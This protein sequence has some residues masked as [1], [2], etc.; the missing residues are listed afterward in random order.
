MKKTVKLMA[1]IMIVAMLAISLSSCSTVI[2]GKYS[3]TA[4][5]AIYEKTTTYEF[6]LFGSLKRT[7]VEE[8]FG[9][10]P[11]TVVT[12]GKYE[13]AEDP[14]NA[15]ELVITLTFGDEST[16][17]SFVQGEENGVKYIKIGG[18][19]YTKAD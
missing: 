1:A 11:K 19:Q 4:D 13:I 8:S 17:Y 9:S 14:E 18:I 3:A 7:V 6:G 16:T 15:E 2:T 12:E 5:L 10:D